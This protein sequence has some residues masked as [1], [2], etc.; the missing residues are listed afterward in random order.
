MDSPPAPSI[1]AD[2]VKRK[3]MEEQKEELDD[4]PAPSEVTE[5]L[6]QETKVKIYFMVPQEDIPN[7]SLEFT[8]EELV[9]QNMTVS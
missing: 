1:L 8:R 2:Y 9:G 4:H 3:K 5:E 6:P 7:M